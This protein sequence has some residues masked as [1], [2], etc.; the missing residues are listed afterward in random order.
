[1]SETLRLIKRIW[2]FLRRKPLDDDLEDELAAH[3]QFAIEDNIARGMS[4]TEARRIALINIGGMDH[5]RYQH[6]QARGF[7]T[8]DIFKQDLKYTLR[9]L[10]HDPS[11][12]VVAVLILALAI[13]A[14]IAVFS[15]VNTL[16]LRPL[17]F[18]AAHQLVWIAP[19]PTK[20]GM[21]CATYST[22]AYDEFRVASRSYQDVTGYFAFSG[23]D[24]LSLNLGGAPLPA[25]GI[26]VIQNFFQVLGVQAQM[27]RVF[28]PDDARNG[29][30]PVILLSNAW[31]KRQF[32]ADPSIIGKA[33][34][35]NGRQTTVIGVLPASFDFGAVF[36][37]GTKVD[38]ITP[39]NLY[40]PPRD[41]GNIITLIGRMKPGVTLDQAVDEAA[42]VAPRM[43]WNN[44]H[45]ETCGEYK[46]SVVPVPL[47]DYIG[48]KLRR[49]LIVLW[50][51][52]GAILLIACVNLSNLLLA[53][54]AAR[55]KEFAMRGALGASRARIVRQLLTESLVL[56]GMG[57]IFGFMLAAVLVEWLAHQGAIALPLLSTLH[58]DGAAL[59]WTV[60]ISFFSATIFGIVPGLRMAGGN[61]Y[62][63]LK[64]AGPGASASRKHERIRSVLV[65]S[66]VA[67][68]CMLL[69][70]A[71]LLLR[72]FMNVLKVDLGFEP[73]HAA[74]IKVPYDDSVPN[75]KD[76]AL[77]AQKRGVLF[78]QILN[79]IAALPGVEAAG[80]TD[81]LPLGQ[82]RSWGL[83]YP[84]GLKPPQGIDG[85]LVYVISPGYMHAMGTPIRGRDFSWSDGP[86]SEQVVMINRS[87]AQ[88]LSN[89]G[90]WP[91]KDALNKPL[92]NGGGAD[93]HVV[94]IVDDVHEENVDGDPGWQ[95]YYPAT[96]ANPSSGE[97][98]VRTRMNPASLAGSVLA[99]LREINPK[100]PAN[101]FRPIRLLVNHAVSGRQFFMLL[102]VSFAALGLLLAALGIYGVISYSVTRQ[103]QEIGIRM[104]LGASAGHVRGRIL[105]STLRLAIIGVGIGIGAS[106]AGAKL[107]AALLF[108]TSPWDVITYAAMALLL[109][110]IAAFSGYIPAFRAS[111]I[112]PT[113]ALRTN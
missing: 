8:L 64:D 89:L 54:A 96:Q 38:A 58:M 3:L 21:S 20:C 5:A 32:N 76:G 44:K 13:G 2:A 87:Y 43:C 82:N 7:M 108:G 39:L 22:D 94:G 63:S 99:T 16:L 49:S 14:N 71:G 10:W 25:T 19:P 101:E 9:T 78:Q 109:L 103:T 4:P 66:E 105:T 6:R 37:P 46:G 112:N 91:D 15:V 77:G 27:G 79:R 59:G 28:T 30:A 84:K 90:A 26:D 107:I 24:N 56:S 95:I 98:V 57:A 68:A 33:F 62:E 110:L 23:A 102:V 69:V 113:V 12:T 88:Y 45:P 55:A 41:W 65:V 93:L 18:P 67:L 1:M 80:F 51:A 106:V 70:G 83:P 50:S 53:R 100:Q 31:W 11:F 52:V 36:A 74:A 73:D 35:I 42:R 72:S 81:Y 48:G 75:D 29:A 104:A 86:K 17:P 34:D 97:L 47:K 40:G 61:V 92:G 111:R 60:L 85:P